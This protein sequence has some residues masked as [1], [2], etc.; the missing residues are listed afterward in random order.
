MAFKDFIK[1]NRWIIST[2]LIAYVVIL[3]GFAVIEIFPFGDQQIMVIDSW[4]QYYPFL[5]ELHH[6]L[7]SGE[8]LFYSWHPGLGVNFF[9]I[10]AYYAFSPIYLLSIVFPKAYLREFM[11]LATGLKIALAGTFFSIYIKRVFDKN[12]ISITLFGLL[13]AFCGF[14]MG[15]YWNIMWLDAVAL[16]PLIIL[17]VH[18]L[19]QHQKWILYTLTLSLALI[20]N[21]YIGFFICLFLLFYFF[22]LLICQNQKI[23]L[24][25]L[26]HKTLTM[27]IA[28]LLAIGIAS[29][30]LIPTYKG[31]QLTHAVNSTFPQVFKP[32]F[33]TLALVNNL[34]PTIAPTVKSGLPNIFSGFASLFFMAFFFASPEIPFRKKVSAFLLTV[35]FMLSFNFNV[36]NYIWHGFHFPN[37]VPYR[38]SFLLSFLLIS[39]GY[40]GFKSYKSVRLRN[41]GIILFGFILFLLIDWKLGSMLGLTVP[42]PDEMFLVSLGLTLL[43]GVLVVVSHRERLPKHTFA[44]GLSILIIGEVVLSGIIGTTSTNSS[45]RQMYPYLKEDVDAAVQYIDTQSDQFTR[46]DMIKWYTTNDPTLYGY[47]GASMFSSTANANVT[48][49]M[50]RIGLAASPESNR[51]LYSSNT[52]VV[53]LILNMNYLLGRNQDGDYPS[54]TMTKVFDSNQV[55]VYRNNYPSTLGFMVDQSFYTWNTQSSDVFDVQEDF[56]RAATK[57]DLSLFRPVDILT[58][59]YVNMNVAAPHDGRYSYTNEDATKVGNVTLHLKAPESKQMYVYMHA[60][61]AYKTTITVHGQATEYEMRR[62]L[63]IDLGYLQKGEDVQI[64]FETQAQYSGFFIVKPVTFDHEAFETVYEKLSK[65]TMTIESFQSTH[66]KGTVNASE[67]GILFTSIPYEK[68]WSV[69]VDGKKIKPFAIQNAF[70]CI[71]LAKGSHT[72]EF[73]YVP[74]GFLLGLTLSLV[75]ILVVIACYMLRLRR[76]KK[77]I[78]SLNQ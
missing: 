65:D 11:M 34:L 32:Y 24:K 55:H 77:Q 26:F 31:L 47:Q 36:L 22:V 71:P 63:I 45:S 4:H 52:P 68:G 64:N 42:M 7:Q 74:D 51:Y 53:N 33:E 76:E 18:Q 69:S 38:F 66:I 56:V 30:V 27:G 40:E 46:T 3:I 5:Q 60:N 39:W 16:L 61:H 59:D 62:G 28:S 43:Y 12:D 57:N 1:R 23:Q 37:E 54:A 19:I 15:Y 70:I 13:Y 21:F 20:S 75:S 2:F 41:V 44:I 17:G 49:L 73:R 50:Q 67:N 8:S 6:K 48:T 35:F 72:V 25:W 10:M 14:N 78:P 29:V 58:A 9:L